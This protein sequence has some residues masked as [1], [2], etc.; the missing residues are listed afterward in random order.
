MLIVELTPSFRLALVLGALHACALC[1]I[2]LT[3]LP[4]W[5]AF[6]LSLAIVGSLVYTLLLHAWRRLPW[7]VVALHC[8]REGNLRVG[9]R[10]GGEKDAHVLP[11]STVAPF[12]TLVVFRPLSRRLAQSA[13]ILPDA[14]APAVFRQL[15]V[16]LKWKVGRGASADPDAGLSHP[17]S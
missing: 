8:D 16:W 11:A 9:Y 3:A 6:I 7:S 14:L 1:C 13:V 5:L 10:D 4:L 17:Q 2:W 12:L 15:R